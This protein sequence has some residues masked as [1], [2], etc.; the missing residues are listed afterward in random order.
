M[1]SCFVATSFFLPPSPFLHS[2]IPLNTSYKYL[3]CKSFQPNH[4]LA[5]VSINKHVTDL[6]KAEHSP[7]FPPFLQFKNNC[8]FLAHT[9]HCNLTKQIL[10]QILRITTYAK[11]TEEAQGPAGFVQRLSQLGRE[12]GTV[13]GRG[14]GEVG[15][16]PKFTHSCSLESKVPSGQ[17][18]EETRWPLQDCGTHLASGLC[19]WSPPCLTDLQFCCLY[20]ESSQ[21]QV[22]SNMTQ[23]PDSLA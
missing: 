16:M 11:A 13:V 20:L 4:G 7:P 3:S 10:H 21:K 6:S 9:L 12:S 2:S 5:V 15:V 23:K 19:S 22:T 14:V 8:L 18:P 1:L 17:R